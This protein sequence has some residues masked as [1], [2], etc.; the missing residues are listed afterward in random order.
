MTEQFR[1]TFLEEVS[2]ILGDLESDLLELETQ[3]GDSRILDGIFRHLHTIKGSGAM[4]GFDEIAGFAHHLETVFD[5]IRQ[6][7]SE[8]SQNLIDLTLAACDLIRQMV[9]SAI[10][11]KSGA[12]SRTEQA[13]DAILSGLE[14]IMEMPTGGN[15]GG[16]GGCASNQQPTAVIFRIRFCPRPDFFHQGHDPIGLLQELGELGFLRSFAHTKNLP[17]L[18]K[19]DPGSCY[20]WWDLIL[21]TNKS[22]NSVR[23]SF[24]FVEGDAA[25]SITQVCG[26]AQ[27]P[28][29]VPDELIEEILRERE[30][31]AQAEPP[32]APGMSAGDAGFFAEQGSTPTETEGTPPHRPQE[33]P[34]KATTPKS[35]LGT[36]T[37]RVPSE[38][39]DALANL[40]G[41]IVTNQARLT[42]IAGDRGDTDL[43][44]VTEI[45]ERLTAELRDTALNLRMMT[46]GVT[47]GH[48]RKLVRNLAAEL[49]KT[50]TLETQ[51]G[52]TEL[53]KTVIEGLSD[54]IVHLLR[55]SVD[56]GIESPREREACGK[57][58]GGTI[59][60]SVVHSGTN[61]EVKVQDDGRGLDSSKILTAAVAKGLLPEAV[62][63]PDREV[64]QILFRPGFSTSQTVS[65]ISGRGVGLDVVRRAVQRLRG[66]VNISGSPGKGAAVTIRLPLSQAII[67]GLL[68]Q[69][70][71]R[72][73]VLPLTAVQ[74]CVELSRE[75]IERA[76]GRQLT[77]VRGEMIPY[78]KLRE[79]FGIRGEPPAIQQVVIAEQNDDRIGFVVDRVIGEHQTVIKSLGR[80]YRGVTQLSGATILGD[81]SIGLILDVSKLIQ[82]AEIGQKPAEE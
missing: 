4:F 74:E 22:L 63:I 18:D 34:E 14:S 10:H 52:E 67:D 53:D 26:R 31:V 51:G 58:T 28:E 5:L 49:G 9:D 23:D 41:E 62:E 27:D 59:R 15:A 21:T 30:D 8:V 81:G 78:L 40:I 11:S 54:T 25:V 61:V 64:F 46:M 44:A 12:D 71:D 2:D 7:K 68:V 66:T 76:N 60:L 38:R 43:T 50:I 57:P 33:N 32:D 37:V 73:F 47:F 56:H 72:F 19:M 77:I 82:Q 45:M 29:K 1:T 80:C 75:E 13:K 39:L 24:I 6:R 16:T 55:N 70:A 42:Q 20:V 17:S 3:P 35:P 36:G 79:T 48:F 65:D 69:V